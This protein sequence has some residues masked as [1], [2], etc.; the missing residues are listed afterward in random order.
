V[1]STTTE[2]LWDRLNSVP[3]LVDDGIYAYLHTDGLQVRV[4]GGN[5]ANYYLTDALGS[6]RGLTDDTGTVIG[7]MSYDVFGAARSH[8]GATDVFGFTGEHVDDVTGFAYLRSRYMDPVLG[9]F[10]S[11]DSVIPNGK[12]TQGFSAYVY[13]ANRTCT[14]TDPTGHFGDCPLAPVIHLIINGMKLQIILWLTARLT[15]GTLAAVSYVKTMGYLLRALFVVL[16]LCLIWVLLVAK[17]IQLG[18]NQFGDGPVD[19]RRL[20]LANDDY[21][22][23]P[24]I[25]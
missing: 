21:P 3:L 1:D 9:R 14:L 18:A 13:V 11:A 15:G 8:T 23:M 16:G 17:G 22:Q 6:V 4:D 25:R 24:R 2:S 19:D 5:A 7:T 12:G 20:R 10:V